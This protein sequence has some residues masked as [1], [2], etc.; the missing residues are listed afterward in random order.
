MQ[1]DRKVLKIKT[2]TQREDPRKRSKRMKKVKKLLAMI[3]AMTMVLGLGLTSFA[4]KTGATITVD[5]LST[6]NTQN[7]SI[8]EIY[9]LDE[10]NNEWVLAE[11]AK[12]TGIATGQTEVSSEVLEELMKAK[13]TT[14]LIGTDDEKVESVLEVL[15]KYA[16]HRMQ[17]SPV[18]G[19]D[20]RMFNPAGANMVEV[21]AGGC[22]VFV[23]DIDKAQK[24]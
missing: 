14:L 4:A 18:S 23:L 10:K 9:R 22:V 12:N 11:W 19:A 24:F 5:G 20:M 21:P 6:A 13:N 15:K 7:V 2:K 1:P 17:L 3:M 16:G 8:Y